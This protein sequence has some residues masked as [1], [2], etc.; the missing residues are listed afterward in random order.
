MKFTNEKRFDLTPSQLERFEESFVVDPITGC[1]LWIKYRDKNGYGRTTV[2]S[3]SARAHRV[4]YEHYRQVK[5]DGILDHIVC[6]NKSCVNPYHVEVS[7][8]R[9]N[10]LRGTA[11]SAHNARKTHCNNGHPFDKVAVW[12]GYKRRVCSICQKEYARR[13]K[14]QQKDKRK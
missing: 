14:E 1:W 13:W 4:A 3:K 10:T 5:A 8:V 7:T 12:S 9:A 2:N 6:D 11:P